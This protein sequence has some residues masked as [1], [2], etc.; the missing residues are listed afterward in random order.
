MA[1]TARQRQKKLEQKNKKKA[2][3][4]KALRELTQ[5]KTRASFHAQYPIHECLVPDGLFQTG[6]ASIFVARRVP[7]GTLAVSSFILDVYCL[8]VKDAFFYV[9]SEYDYEH[10]LKAPMIA[11][12]ED[13]QFESIH[14]LCVKKLIEGAVEY[15]RALGFSPHP[16]Y[17]KAK[18][19][20]GDMD[21]G[22]C[23]VRY[24]YGRESKPCY[25]RGP[26]ESI[27]RAREIVA[28]LAGKCGEGNFDY[29]VQLDEEPAALE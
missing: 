3:A 17:R 16:D 6:L 29:I 14:V 1:I 11:Q 15:A 8:G 26:N 5:S 19:L 28:Q 18:A 23:P 7:D 13:Q 27:A 24:E 25:I 2:L 20:L 10:K 9:L 21:T 12:H 4:K 22:A